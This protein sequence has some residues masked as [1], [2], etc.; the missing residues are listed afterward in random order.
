MRQWQ[1][2][3]R[4]WQKRI[5]L[6]SD[7]SFIATTFDL[8]LSSSCILFNSYPATPLVYPMDRDIFLKS[9][10]RR[11]G[12]TVYREVARLVIRSH[13]D[14]TRLTLAP[15]YVLDRKSHRYILSWSSEEDLQRPLYVSNST[16]TALSPRSISAHVLILQGLPLTFSRRPH[17][18]PY[19]A[20]LS[21]SSPSYYIFRC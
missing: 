3:L 19:F 6:H 13:L 15:F 8:K 5:F 10:K 16:I 21:C 2:Q 7:G 1:A 9:V 18:K 12:K 11:K 17:L 14:R 4:E 20:S